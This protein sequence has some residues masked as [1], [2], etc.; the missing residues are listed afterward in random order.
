MANAQSVRV[1]PTAVLSP[2]AELA[3]GVEVGPHVV[4]EGRVRVGPGCVLR[5]GVHLFGPLTLGRGNLL[6]SGV[7]LGERPQH[8]KYNGEATGLEVGDHNIFREH[9]TV[10]RATTHSWTTRIGSHN[11]FMANSHVAH[12]CVVGNHCILA[13]GALVGGHCELHDGAYLSGNCAIHQ[14]VRV[15]RL[16]M[17]SGCSATTKDI[18]P[19]IIQQNIDSVVGVNVVGMRRAGISNDQINAVRQAFRVL[20]RAGLV[21]PQALLILERDHAGVPAVMEIVAFL[22]QARRGINPIRARGREEAA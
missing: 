14:F 6:Y 17:L 1:H 19:F 9:V 18:P 11:F 20:F 12:D 15:G 4:I 5:P 10:H 16:A 22:R 13:N 3:E 7:V 2:E 21:L 8:S